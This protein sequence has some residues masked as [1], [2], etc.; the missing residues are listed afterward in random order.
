MGTP[1]CGTLKLNIDASLL[2]GNWCGMGPVVRDEEGSIL[3]YTSWAIT[4][5]LEAH[6]AKA[7]ACVLGLQLTRDHCFVD[8]VLETNNIKVA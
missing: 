4:H 8:I 7:S 6:E 1:P 5:S 3:A 2:N